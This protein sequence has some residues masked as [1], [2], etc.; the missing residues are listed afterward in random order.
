M[1]ILLINPPRSPENNILRYAPAEARRFIHKKL[2]GPPLGLLTIAA[3]VKDHDVIVFDTKGEY[4]LVPDAPS[5]DLMVEG[6]LEKHHPQIVGVTVITSEFDYSIEIFRTVKRVDASILTVAGGLHPTLCPGDF[7]DPSVDLVIPGQSSHIF[8]ELVQALEKGTSFAAIPGL[9]INSENGLKKTTGKPPVWDAAD[10]G[11]LMPDRAH[12][13]RWI[14]TYK[15]GNSPFPSTYVFTSLGCPY[16]CTFCSIW[17]QFQGKYYQRTIESLIHELKSID[18]YPVVRFADA[19]TVVDEQFMIALFDRIEK[20]GISKTFIMDIRADVAAHRPD[21]IEK[22]AR[23]GLKVVIC[24][25]E[26]FR[27]EELRRYHKKSPVFDNK[28]AVKVFE[29]NGIMVRGN[30]VIPNDYSHADFESLAEYANQNRVVY[31]GYT[32]LTPM[33][34]TVFHKQVKDQ[35]VDH[36]YRKYNF[37][38]SVMKTTLPHDEFHAK[39]GALWLIKKGTDVI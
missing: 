19:N 27:D 30:Y 22:L 37:F 12:L 29:Q 32:V 1:K 33:P 7:Q 13:K 16:K 6:L 2:I 25:F 10:T 20:E 3:A 28:M 9:W 21:I 18:E 5:L 17:S 15:V 31:A 14:D 24:G 26:S 11:F 38:N 4:D 35:I 34:G 36:D 39:V 8:R 23:G